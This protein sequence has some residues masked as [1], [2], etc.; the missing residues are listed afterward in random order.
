MT[1]IYHYHDDK[2]LEYKQRILLN[3]TSCVFCEINKKE[4]L[5]QC[6]ECDKLFCNGKKGIPK[7][8]LFITYKNPPT[9]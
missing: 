9:K 4:I 2:D 5:I 1:E 7:V 6:K 3:K 8:I